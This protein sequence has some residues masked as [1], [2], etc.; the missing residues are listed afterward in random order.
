[1]GVKDLEG[2]PKFDEITKNVK[3]IQDDMER[4][5]KVRQDQLRLA[6]QAKAAAAR[7]DAGQSL[8]LQMAAS[9]VA[10]TISSSRLH[11][12]T[13]VTSAP[14][15][16]QPGGKKRKTATSSD[17]PSTRKAKGA[18]ASC[19]ALSVGPGGAMSNASARDGC[20]K[21]SASVATAGF[22]DVLAIDASSSGGGPAKPQSIEELLECIMGRK[23]YSPGRELRWAT[24]RSQP[25]SA[26]RVFSS[27]S[28][29]FLIVQV[30][31]AWMLDPSLALTFQFSFVL[32]R[33]CNLCC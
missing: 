14:V 25:G 4:A 24:E 10:T 11:K 23:S 26:R 17:P 6:D 16:Q 31:G 12:Q 15:P 13:V 33:R 29:L 20:G 5:E 28:N 18:A 9:N 8:A 19:G 1:M 30:N 7:G 32:S 22:A 3:S 21:S 27:M 2:L